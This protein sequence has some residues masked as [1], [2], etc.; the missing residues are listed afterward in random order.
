MNWRCCVVLAGMLIGISGPAA[1]GQA[2]MG[3]AAMGTEHTH[4]AAAA[5]TAL[6]LT[7]GGKATKLS[8]AELEAMPQKTITVR[9]AHTD[10]DE[11][12]SGVPVGDLLAKFGAPYEKNEKVIYHSYLRAGGMDGY[13]VL[14]S[15]SEVESAMHLGDVIVATRVGGQPL[16]A[17]G[18]FRLVASEEKK[19]ARWVRNLSTLELKSAE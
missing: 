6:T 10:K 12:Y 13:W 3:Q 8:V 19:P 16:G 15:A 14:Y 18:Q 5:S 1:S 9:N 4:M 17:D 7:V 11:T 2:A